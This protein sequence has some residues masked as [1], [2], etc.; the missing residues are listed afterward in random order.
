MHLGVCTLL[1]ARNARARYWIGAV[2]VLVAI[3]RLRPLQPPQ[4]IDDHGKQMIGQRPT[5]ILGMHRSEQ[6]RV[7]RGPLNDD[8]KVSPVEIRR[9]A[10]PQP[11]A[12]RDQVRLER[13]AVLFDELD[14]A[15]DFPGSGDS[16]TLLIC[17]MIGSHADPGNPMT[18]LW[19]SG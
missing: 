8:Q 2:A 18:T 6:V 5:G 9:W 17:T 10:I 15:G 4:N 14:E 7:N 3:L 19:L 1:F 16:P 12:E 13:L 11:Q